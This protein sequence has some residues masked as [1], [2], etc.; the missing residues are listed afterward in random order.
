MASS[1]GPAHASGRLSDGESASRAIPQAGRR[2]AF[3]GRRPL[4]VVGHYHQIVRNRDMLPRRQEQRLRCAPRLRRSGSACKITRPVVLQ[5]NGTDRGT[6]A[7]SLRNREASRCSTTR[8]SNIGPP[9]LRACAVAGTRPARPRRAECSK[10]SSSRT[11]VLRAAH[12]LRR[13]PRCC[14]ISTARRS[15]P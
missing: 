4:I 2:I 8:I 10:R 9:S 12:R 3:A 14:S 11:V 1:L 7:G 5:G 6:R 15:Q 13:S